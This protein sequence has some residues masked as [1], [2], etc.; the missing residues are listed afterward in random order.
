[1]ND[2]DHE[3]IVTVAYL[4][5]LADGRTAPEEDTEL[6]AALGRL[7]VRDVDAVAQ[8]GAGARAPLA[9]LARRL[10]DDDARRLA[11]DTA[12]VVCH[13]DGPL[14]RQEADFLSALRSALGLAPTTLSEME[15][16]AA[17]L[18]AVQTA[19]P[20]EVGSGQPPGGDALD[21][22][23]LQQAMIT[24]AVE[25]LPDKLANLV[26]LPL[27]LRM[28]YQIGQ[29][30]GQKLDAGQIKDLAATL[31]LGAAAQVMEGVVRKLVGG[32]TGGLFGGLVGGAGGIAAGAA[33]TFSATYAL[34]H[35]AKQYYAQGRRLST[36][37]LRAL[38]HRFQEDAKSLFPK[39]QNEIQTKARTLNL[40]TLFD[41]LR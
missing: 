18:A 24:S 21:H 40:R 1:M 33:V 37:D 4:A 35:V 25:L 20:V 26:I 16:S 27:Q 36:Q 3:T 19:A 28:V 34:G 29:N 5:A 12:L 41:E 30:Y 13:A 2:S 38:F 31:G 23:I 6:R 17:R 14:N 10:S 32:V 15:Q 22:L 8:R 9:D 11:Y 39:V 7:G